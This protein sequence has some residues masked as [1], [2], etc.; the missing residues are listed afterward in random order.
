MAVAG[1]RVA[2]KRATA[3]ERRFL[4]IRPSVCNGREYGPYRPLGPVPSARDELVGA[5]RLEDRGELGAE[6]RPGEAIAR[7]VAG[8]LAAP[9]ALGAGAG[10]PPQRPGEAPPGVGAGE[11]AGL[12]PAGEGGRAVAVAGGA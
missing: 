12:P 6:R 1:T 3:R 7:V 8:Q 5:R 11:P 9:A 2:A 4:V 10:G